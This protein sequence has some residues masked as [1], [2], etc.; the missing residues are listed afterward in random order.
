MVVTGD[1]D[2]F[3][4]V[5]EGV[6]VHG[7][8]R[9]GSPRRRSTT[10]QAV[11]EPLR[12]AAE[13]D[14]RLHG[15]EGRHLATTSPASPGSA[16]RRRRSCCRQFGTLEG[17]CQRRSDLRGQTQRE[18]RRHA[19]DARYVASSWRRCGTTSRRAGVDAAGARW[20]A[21]LDRRRPCA[22]FM[23]EFELRAVLQRLDDV[24]DPRARRPRRS[25]RSSTERG[26]RAARGRE[27]PADARRA[28]ARARGARPPGHAPR[29]AAPAAERTVQAG[30]FG[31]HDGAPSRSRRMQ[32]RRRR[33]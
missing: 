1:R 23:R 17:A 29:P 24:A 30:R 27:R 15:P 4:L 26:A 22:E 6:R 11:V 3:Q 16:T 13:A 5:G 19:E 33:P 14:D 21:S 10:R 28:G 20:R 32:A 31:A 12:G 7:A 9:A 18:R 25:A 8:P 2:A